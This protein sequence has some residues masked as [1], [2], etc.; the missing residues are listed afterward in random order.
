MKQSQF[1]FI[2]LFLLKLST[3]TSTSSNPIVR[4][5]LTYVFDWDFIAKL[6]VRIAFNHSTI[7]STSPTNKLNLLNYNLSVKI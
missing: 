3:V 1:L 5:P 6:P 7:Y 4:I 2:I